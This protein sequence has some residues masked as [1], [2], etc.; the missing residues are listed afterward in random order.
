MQ[1]HDSLKIKTVRSFVHRGRAVGTIKQRAFNELWK[2]FGLELIDGKI[3]PDEL[4]KR[5]AKTVI[6]IGFG[7]GDSLFSMAVTHPEINFIGIEVHRP[8]IG[9]LLVKLQTQPI[10]NLRIYAADAVEVLEQCV[11][12]NTIDQVLIFF[13]DP[14][15][16]RKHY[17][18]RLIQDNFVELLHKKLR[19]D[20][21]LHI[22]TDWEDYA[23]HVLQVMKSA[24]GWQAVNHQEK[25]N[26][27]AISK[28]EQRGLKL[29]H[30]IW[31]LYYKTSRKNF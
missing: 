26:L 31:D 22:A 27:R 5:K 24:P 2:I 20:G 3:N 29:G 14:W 6:E 4:F 28:F 8:G 17:K 25:I 11:N 12:D 7:M 1:N 30:K 13:P 21:I 16:K 9:A 23:K 10:N 15:P 19:A 18:R